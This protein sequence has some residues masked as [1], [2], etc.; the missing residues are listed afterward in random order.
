MN[1]GIFY[2]YEYKNHQKHRNVGFLK[3][4]R[5]YNTCTLQL[6]ARGIPVTRQD[7]LKLY[8]FYMENETARSGMIAEIPCNNQSVSAK[9]NIAETAFPNQHTLND[10]HGFFLPISDDRILAV[11]IPGI[12]LDTR[13]IKYPAALEA[14]S[15]NLCPLPQTEPS[16]RTEQLPQT[17]QSP[18]AEQP[19]QAE[20]PPQTEQ[21]PRTEQPPQAEQ[22]PRVEQPP[23][24]EQL[25]LAEQPPRTEQP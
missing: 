16:S 18:Q 9:L 10:I 1:P 5:H 4:I 12:T 6:H 23:Q 11:T 17:E 3:L 8:A 13:Q 21:P 19:S 20:Q 22:P 2:L 24:A 25:P 14:E 7:T 15:L